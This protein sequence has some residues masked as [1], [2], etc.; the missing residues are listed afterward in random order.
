MKCL[1]VFKGEHHLDSVVFL[2]IISGAGSQRPRSGL[3]EEGSIG[4]NEKEGNIRNKDNVFLNRGMG[5]TLSSVKICF[6][7][8]QC[9]KSIENVPGH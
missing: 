9:V 5:K 6:F 1:N 7:V 2:Y 8:F 3:K 4:S